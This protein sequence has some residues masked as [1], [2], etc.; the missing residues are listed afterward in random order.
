MESLLNFVLDNQN[1]INNQTKINI[2]IGQNLGNGV[3]NIKLTKETC[4][5]ILEN[6]KNLELPYTINTKCYRIYKNLDM[7]YRISSNEET[8]HSKEILNN[9]IVEIDNVTCCLFLEKT[10][11]LDLTSFSNC[12]EYH[13]ILNTNIVK[14]YINNLFYLV[15]T[16]NE[17]SQGSYQ[18]LSIELNRENI[19]K[20]KIKDNLK[21]IIEIVVKNYQD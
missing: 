4:K 15:I 19:Y 13:D 18:T 20:D 9:N 11:D 12:Q 16:I 14:F 3:F 17:T 2:K 1:K 21:K 10:V 5:K 7:E 8:N 6:I